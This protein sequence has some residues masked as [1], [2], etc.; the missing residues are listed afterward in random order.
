M[1]G[2]HLL[3]PDTHVLTHKTQASSVNEL[4]TPQASA[5]SCKL[6]TPMIRS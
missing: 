4:P 1:L 2:T 3:L 6:I 5:A